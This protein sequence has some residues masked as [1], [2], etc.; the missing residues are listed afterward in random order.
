MIGLAA[1]GGGCCGETADML[2]KDV[3]NCPPTCDCWLALSVSVSVLVRG[4]PSVS[5]SELL[6]RT[7]LSAASSSFI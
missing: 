1:G 2:V 4:E 5:S 7:P 6:W 3:P